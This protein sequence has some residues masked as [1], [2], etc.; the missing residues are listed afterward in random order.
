MFEKKKKIAEQNKVAKSLKMFEDYE[1][2]TFRIGDEDYLR[3]N[4]EKSMVETTQ[5]VKIP[6]SAAKRLY[7]NIIAKKDIKGYDIEGYTVISINGTLKIDCHHINI[8][9]VHKVGKQ[10]LSI[11]A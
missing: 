1:I 11:K 4:L 3:M 10:L 7:E 6:V 9:S 8:D 2:N 5:G